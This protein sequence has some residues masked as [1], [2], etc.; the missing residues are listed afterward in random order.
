M[1]EINYQQNSSLPSCRHPSIIEI[2][3]VRSVSLVRCATSASIYFHI[4]HY[5]SFNFEDNLQEVQHPFLHQQLIVPI[6]QHKYF[7]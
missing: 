2:A 6:E 7:E 5:Q 3:F 1:F 4:F